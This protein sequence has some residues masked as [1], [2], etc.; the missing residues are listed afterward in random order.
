LSRDRTGTGDRMI[1]ARWL[2]AAWMF[3][4]ARESRAFRRATR[5]VAATQTNVLVGIMA[6]NRDTAFGRGNDFRR[7]DD[8]RDFQRRVPL[9]SYD[10]YADS[11]R[12][13]ADGEH[14][15]LT[16]ERVE[17][18]EPTSGSIGGEKLI[19]YTATLRRPL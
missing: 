4:A 12:R 5:N 10:D 3:A 16:A 18:L 2:N 9:S 8:L 19:P 1:P 6:A 7:I 11:I 14:G 17:L 13:I 15:V